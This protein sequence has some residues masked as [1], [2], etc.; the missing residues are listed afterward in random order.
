MLLSLTCHNTWLTPQ[1][2]YTLG[3]VKIGLPVKDGVPSGRILL[4]DLWWRNRSGKKLSC[5]SKNKE[6]MQRKNVF[7]LQL[8]IRFTQTC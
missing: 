2:R 7:S 6:Q 5:K 1:R 4:A 8:N 3:S